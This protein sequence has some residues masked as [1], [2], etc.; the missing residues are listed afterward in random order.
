[1]T[2]GTCQ[3]AGENLRELQTM[4]TLTMGKALVQDSIQCT[5]CVCTKQ[6]RHF[7]PSVEEMACLQIIYIK[8]NV[9]QGM[10]KN[11]GKN[12]ITPRDPPTQDQDV[13][14]KYSRNLA[15]HLNPVTGKFCV[16]KLPHL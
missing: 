9:T 10:H 1:M 12:G 14:S 13:N 15:I 2:Q 11:L 6:L 4:S 8:K 5:L 7:L 16:I 3:A